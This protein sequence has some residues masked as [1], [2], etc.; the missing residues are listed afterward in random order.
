MSMDEAKNN[1]AFAGCGIREH[2]TGQ[3]PDSDAR[4]HGHA[5]SVNPHA[6]ANKNSNSHSYANSEHTDPDAHTST[7]GYPNTNSDSYT[8]ASADRYTYTNDRADRHPDVNADAYSRTHRHAPTLDGSGNRR[9]L[10]QELKMNWQL[11]Q[12]DPVNHDLHAVWNIVRPGIERVRI[13]AK[14]PW[15]AEDVYTAVVTGRATMHV[16]YL[17]QQY[18]GV[19]VLAVN[20]DSFSKEKSLLVWALYTE[21]SLA[22]SYGL[23][24]VYDIARRQGIYKIVFHSPRPG[25]ERRMKSI[26]FEIKERIYE[27]SV[28][29]LDGGH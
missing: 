26:G 20:V 23:E 25:W 4:A 28:P 14:A 17:D 16:G 13:K 6:D 12:I 8:D 1:T 11:L 7:H 5:N 29:R 15:I 27:A 24:D 2:G 22:L 10:D 3:D 19:L 21:H 9:G 18:A